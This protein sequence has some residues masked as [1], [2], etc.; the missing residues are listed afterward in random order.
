[1]TGSCLASRGRRLLI[2]S[3]LASMGLAWFSEPGR[4][5]SAADSPVGNPALRDIVASGRLADLRWPNFS[6]YKISVLKFYEP[7][8]FAPAWVREAAPS[9]QALSMIDL[10]KNAWKKG[11]EP[12]DYDAS[13]WDGR[14][15]GLQAA[16]TD[17]A[18]FDVALTVCTMRLVSDLRIGRI[19]P[20]H[21]QFDLS[22]EHKK[23]DLAQFLRDRLLPASDIPALLHSVEPPFAGYRRTEAALARYVELARR[24]D[25][26][27]LLA[28]ATPVKPGQTYRGA[29]R[30]NRLLR[31]VGDL[32]PDAA[33][34]ADPE[35]YDGALVEAVKHFQRRHGLA[36]DGRLGPDT[37]KQLNVPLADRVRQ[38]Q[39]SLERWRWLPTQFSSP[40][41][42]V[43]VP[44]F[45]LRALDENYKVALEMR[46]VVGRAMRTQTPV[47]SRDMTY[48]VLRPYWNVPQSILRSEIVPAI[49]RNRD[50]IANKGYEVTTHSGTV[51]TSGPISDDVLSQL[52]AGK[53]AVRQMPGPN[54]A[55]GL[56]K[57]MFPNEYNVY[58]HSTP[59]PELFSRIRRDF[60]HG[61]IRV[62]RP[63]ELATW[64]LRDN[65]GWT[66]ER[67]QQGMQTGPDNVTVRLARRVPV[68]IVYATAL[69]HENDEVHFY[70]D[71]YGHDATLAQALARGYPYP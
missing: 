71:I 21:F 59:A 2:F 16:G 3:A 10:F 32:P 33:V 34:P 7:A 18:P 35:L 69:A 67:V 19:N 56:V 4:Q 9:P 62:E 52:K 48:L 53:L 41:I 6:D 64:V 36:D 26:E 45:R 24:D 20:K 55:L 28:P 66:L 11:L 40:P 5:A 44:D 57:L 70:D 39:L 14:L 58:L 30:L 49:Q 25:P 22:V 13:R 60:S 17:P 38:L 37:L 31:T 65:S 54:N 68:F 46:V 15:Q 27:E 51:V 50:Y 8:G 43:N 42:I 61:C 29:P 47:F 12:E 63:A 23:Y 1:M